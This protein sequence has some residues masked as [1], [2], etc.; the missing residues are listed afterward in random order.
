MGAVKRNGSEKFKNNL[1]YCWMFYKWIIL[2]AAVV[3]SAVIYLVAVKAT[4]KET[5]LSVILM[6]CHTDVT[7]EQMEADYLEA[8][9]LGE[10]G[11]GAE[12]QTSLM[13]S[14][15]GSGSYAM[16][17]L[18]KF[19]ADVGSEKLDV[20]AMTETDFAKYVESDCFV[21]LENS[22][23]QEELDRLEDA[24]YVQDG[25]ILGL[26]T[27]MLPV[28]EGYECYENGERGVIGILYNAPHPENAAGYLRYLA[29]M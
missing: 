3:L 28:L 18:S 23:T 26:Y 22:L 10:E 16:S 13:L 4:E 7:Q 24:C 8:S 19:L 11:Y 17:S 14:D 20:C 2:A 27:D 15:A 9:G 5:A 12:I 29:G 25:K 1:R 21:S 6:D